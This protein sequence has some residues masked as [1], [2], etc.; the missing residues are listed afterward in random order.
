MTHACD[1][2]A[3]SSGRVRLL[4]SRFSFGEKGSKN[5]LKHDQIDR[6]KT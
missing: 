6:S 2:E 1:R 5:F 3:N 4:S